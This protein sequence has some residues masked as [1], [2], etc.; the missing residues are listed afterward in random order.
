MRRCGVQMS[1]RCAHLPTGVS[2]SGDNRM[3]TFTVYP[4][5]QPDEGLSTAGKRS[6]QA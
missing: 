3:L 1:D 5:S 4:T 6:A 2:N